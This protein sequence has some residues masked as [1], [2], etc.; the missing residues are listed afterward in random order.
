MLSM[1]VSNFF[2]IANMEACNW[3]PTLILQ[4][5]RLVVDCQLQY[6]KNKIWWLVANFNIANMKVHVWSLAF[7]TIPLFLYLRW[8]RCFLNSL[9]PFHLE[10]MG[11]FFPCYAR[12]SFY[13]QEAINTL[14]YTMSLWQNWR[15]CSRL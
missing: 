15:V 9:F 5:W 10:F 12:I 8:I 13:S 14:L 1:F 7:D 6:C 11:V 3:L 2:D 4:T